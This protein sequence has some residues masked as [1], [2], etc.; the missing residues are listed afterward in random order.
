VP[1]SL[2]QVATDLEVEILGERRQANL[3]P[4]PLH[5]PTSSRMRLS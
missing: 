4:R 5:D 3:T 1:A 2:A